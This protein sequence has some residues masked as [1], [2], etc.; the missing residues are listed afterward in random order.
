MELVKVCT[1]CGRSR[2]IYVMKDDYLKWANRQA[3]IQDAMPYLSAEER[4]MLLSGICPDCWDN[5]FKEDE[6]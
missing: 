3:L 1:I 2:V 4:E 5:L 6:D